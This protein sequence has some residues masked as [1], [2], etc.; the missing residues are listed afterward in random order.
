MNKELSDVIFGI[1]SGH[2]ESWYLVAE[3]ITKIPY[4]LFRSFGG[5]P[6]NR[7]TM[8][9]YEES[10]IEFLLYGKNLNDL[11]VLHRSIIGDLDNQ[12]LYNSM[13]TKNLI[14]NLRINYVDGAVA[15]DDYLLTFQYNY[16]LQ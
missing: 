2:V 4:C 12:S 16:E 7:D 5:S 8:T 9:L 1:I 3:N 10:F 6:Y 13:P 11:R 14:K 15:K